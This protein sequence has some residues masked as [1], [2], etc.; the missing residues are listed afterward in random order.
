MV[1]TEIEVIHFRGLS[2]LHLREKVHGHPGRW[3]VTLIQAGHPL[4]PPVTEAHMHRLMQEPD[5][6][7]RAVMLGTSQG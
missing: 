5:G 3:I 1:A 4:L 6:R 2:E 7:V